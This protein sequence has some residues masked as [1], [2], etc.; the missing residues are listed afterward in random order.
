MKMSY[1][2]LLSLIQLGCIAY[3]ANV[4]VG[5][6]P[7]NKNIRDWFKAT[8]ISDIII[9][10]YA[11]MV[12][13]DLFFNLSLIKRSI[14]SEV[15]RRIPPRLFP[16]QSRSLVPVL[17]LIR[18]TDLN[19]DKC[20]EPLL[21]SNDGQLHRLS[22]V[23]LVPMLKSQFTTD[24]L[25]RLIDFYYE[26]K[27]YICQNALEAQFER[28][29]LEYTNNRI[30]GSKSTNLWEALS[31]VYPRQLSVKSMDKSQK[32]VAIAR[33]ISTRATRANIENALKD[34]LTQHDVMDNSVL[35]DCRAYL[36]EPFGTMMKTFDALNR[37]ETMNIGQK[38]ETLM[39]AHDLCIAIRDL[40]ESDIQR[41]L[42]RLLNSSFPSQRSTMSL[43][44]TTP[45][46]T[47]TSTDQIQQPGRQPASGLR[48]SDLAR[49]EPI[50][51]LSLMLEP[52]NQNE[53]EQSHSS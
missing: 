41:I 18:L 8:E 23:D 4:V 22:Y 3:Y 40:Q 45:I 53:K 14:N 7:S 19:V 5:A 20:T 32:M 44:T 30:D 46:S 9:R 38:Y 6:P 24:N 37:D 43:I 2:G 34:K 47:Q 48:H 28:K 13:A 33:Y 50:T 15:T 25:I 51:N 49:L 39:R 42:E 11:T 26:S 35:R 36:I 16:D 12:D 10:N 29:V 21:D 52:T 1:L 17:A 31:K 27:L